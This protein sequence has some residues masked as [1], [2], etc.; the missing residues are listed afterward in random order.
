[1]CVSDTARLHFYVTRTA[2]STRRVRGMVRPAPNDERSTNS[3]A[4]TS[5]R[6]VA[7]GVSRAVSQGLTCGIRYAVTRGRGTPGEVRCTDGRR[8][9]AVPGPRRTARLRSSDVPPIVDNIFIPL[10]PCRRRPMKEM[11]VRRTYL[12]GET[13]SGAGLARGSILVGPGG[14]DEAHDERPT[15]STAQ[16]GTRVPDRQIIRHGQIRLPR[17]G[18]AFPVV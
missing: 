14:R 18:G 7:A 2:H 13:C 3:R 16:A 15:R 1:M 9:P 11:V 10:L 17:I 5:G 4:Q 6:R 8:V 12:F